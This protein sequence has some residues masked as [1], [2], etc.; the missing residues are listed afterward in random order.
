MPKDKQST[1]E[2]LKPS[3]VKD[4]ELAQK[5]KPKLRKAVIHKIVSTAEENFK[6][7]Q[8]ED[9]KLNDKTNAN[10]AAQLACIALFQERVWEKI[11]P[12]FVMEWLKKGHGTPALQKEMED[13]VIGFATFLDREYQ[14][15]LNLRNTGK[16][17]PNPFAE[18]NL[19]WFWAKFNVDLKLLVEGDQSLIKHGKK[20]VVSQ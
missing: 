3:E 14:N 10:R 13:D 8:E 7:K 11:Q 15:Y 4:M 9:K 12:Y 6:K 5:I 16:G 17:Y 1:D 20:G 18:T 2:K 19:L